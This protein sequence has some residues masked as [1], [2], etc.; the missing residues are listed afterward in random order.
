MATGIQEAPESS[1]DVIIRYSVCLNAMCLCGGIY[2]QRKKLQVELHPPRDV[3][4]REA[5]PPA[6]TSSEIH[7]PLSGV[8]ALQVGRAQKLLPGGGQAVLMLKMAEGEGPWN[9]SLQAECGDLLV[10]DSTPSFFFFFIRFT[11]SQKL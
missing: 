7:P 6:G 4:V 5:A 10:H 8:Q 9:S 1:R 11:L 2:A 3:P